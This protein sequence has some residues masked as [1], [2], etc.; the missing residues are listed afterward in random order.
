MGSVH[1]DRDKWRIRWWDAEGRRRSA[2]FKSKTT[3]QRALAKFESE[4]HEIRV[5]LRPTPIPERT[6]DDLADYWLEHRTSRKKSKRDDI[7]IINKSFRPFFGG[8]GVA[9]VTLERIDAYRRHKCPDERSK[10]PTKRGRRSDG[11]VSVKTLHNHLTLLISMLNLAVD[12]GWIKSRPTVKKPK[13]QPAEYSYIR[14]REEIQRFLVEAA[15]EEDGV[16]ELYAAAV[17]TGMRA[18]ELLGLQWQDVDLERR[19]ITVQRSYDTSTKSDRIRHVPILDTLLPV[20]KAWKLR[21]TS[22]TW[23][24]PNQAGNMHQPSA[25]VLQEHLHRVRE[26]AGIEYRFRF[27]D[28]RHT[29]AS[30]W[31][32]S[33]GDIYRLQRILG[34]QSIV[35]T[36]RYSHLSPG[37]FAEDYDRLGSPLAVVD[38]RCNLGHGTVTPIRYSKLHPSD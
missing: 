3:A 7:S 33:G 29:F 11:T 34:H 27:H 14:T 21:C 13:L 2:T 6:F 19:L 1:K 10:G 12:L 31:M 17:Y 28:L 18:G 15:E 30:H 23:V 26:R 38:D 4:A 36:E 24:Y 8:L 25:R 20:L 32:M 37:V 16:F 5:G 9:E 22:P 35:M